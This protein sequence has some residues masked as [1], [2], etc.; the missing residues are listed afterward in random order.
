MTARHLSSFI[1]TGT[2]EE[3]LSLSTQRLAE[4]VLQHLKSYA[5]ERTVMQNGLI[6]HRYFIAV[7]E[8]R[9]VGLGATNMTPEY[10]PRQPE[11]SEALEEAWAWLVNQ[12]MLVKASGQPDE[13]FKITRDGEACLARLGFIG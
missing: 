8:G 2:A 4:I 5:A 6:H 11:V 1:G 3:L 10:G 9:N 7:I 12:G 13:W